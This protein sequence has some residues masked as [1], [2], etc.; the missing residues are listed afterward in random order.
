MDEFADLFSSELAT[1]VYLIVSLLFV[2]LYIAGF[3]LLRGLPS[4][5]NAMQQRLRLQG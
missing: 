3:L 1:R 5:H 2:L 4:P